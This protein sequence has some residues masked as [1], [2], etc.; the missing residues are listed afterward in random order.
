[1]NEL[2]SE[3]QAT[4]LTKTKKAMNLLNKY[5]DMIMGME[6]L[7]ELSKNRDELKE[8]GDRRGFDAFCIMHDLAHLGSRLI[9]IIKE[10][11]IGQKPNGIFYNALFD[12][13]EKGV[14]AII[15]CEAVSRYKQIYKENIFNAK[16][17]QPFLKA[18]KEIVRNLQLL[19]RLSFYP[20]GAKAVFISNDQEVTVEYDFDE[21]EKAFV[22]KFIDGVLNVKDATISN[23]SLKFG[24]FL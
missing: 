13:P 11:E 9:N 6:W 21:P 23:L 16:A 18:I 1:M 8:K 20:D 19:P 12:S 14:M 24:E 10:L 22:S 7:Q 17:T 4:D 3:T 15:E 2:P 5:A